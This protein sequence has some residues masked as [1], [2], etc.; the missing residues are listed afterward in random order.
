MA[1]RGWP[2]IKLLPQKTN[3][4][5]VRYAKPAAFISVI[6]CVAALV[7]CF[8]PGLNMGIDFR[9]GASLEVAKPAGQV[10]NLEDVRG[11]VSRLDLGDV[12]VQGIARRDTNIDDGSTAIVRFQIPEGR[13]QTA[14]VTD[15]ETAISQATGQ[16]TYSGVN[17][18]GSK[19]SG[20][21]FMSGLIALGS[22]IGLMFLYIWF[23]FEPQFGFGAVAGLV[24]D[25]I[26]TFGLIVVFRLEF[27]LTM[28]A[29]ILT[30]IGY[31]MNDTVVVFDRLR[32]NLRKYKAMPLR[33]VI[34]L[35]LNETL[36]R[37]II[38]G[39][40]AVMVLAA[41]AVFGGEALF[42]FSIALMF[43]IIIGTYSSIYVGAPIILLWGVKRGGPSDDAKPIK[44]GMASR[45]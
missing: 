20:E 16:V 36:S 25:V 15:V 38:T 27:S 39:V 35:S 13:D 18:V 17:V 1:M 24:H 9:G 7:S 45:P 5:F 33:D 11:A 43:G 44:L 23:R 37:T 31:S 8:M 34:D 42:G 29:A 22:A 12:G 19:V 30:V 14:V 21:L 10:I 2:L 40:T 41:L 26:L 3:F 6:L 32:E 28:V 4:R